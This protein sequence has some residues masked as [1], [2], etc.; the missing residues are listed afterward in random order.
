MT[1]GARI[2]IIDYGMGNLRSV[3]KGLERV[4]CPAVVT[5]DSAVIEA[6]DGVVFPGVGAFR[7]CMDNLTELDLVGTVRKVVERDTPFLGICLGMQLLFETSEEFGQVQGLGLLRG[8]VVRF[9][10]RPELQVPHMGW[11]Q[12]RKQGDPACLR[13][14]S[15]GA[16]VYFVHSYHVVPAENAVI[17]TTNGL[18]RRVR[19][20]CPPGQ[21][22]CVPVSSREEPGRGTP[23]LREL[24]GRGAGRRIVL[25]VPAIDL[26][27]GRCV[28]LLRGDMDAETVYGDDPLAMGQRWVAEGAQY[29]HVVDLDGAVQGNPV[30]QEAI[31]ALCRELPI[32]VEVGGG[33]R[34]AQQADA[35]IEA[36]ADRVIFGTAA[37][38]DPQAVAAACAAHPARSRWASMPAT[39]W[40]RCRVGR[41]R[42]GAGRTKL[43]RRWRASGSIV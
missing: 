20:R 13:G 1:D 10:R 41:K 23:D 33:I 17:A 35:L 18:R 43:Q 32:P 38:T 30:N 34:T 4:G 11:N 27:G 15:D 21:L 12:I 8:R 16:Y 25:I 40:S 31:H 22:V 2:A 29:L 6:A 28:R 19:V 26:K 39:V 42:P 7:A 36:G 24:C 14:I 3:Q 37:L 5:R 9:P